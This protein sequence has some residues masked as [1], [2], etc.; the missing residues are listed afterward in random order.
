MGMKRSTSSMHEKRAGLSCMRKPWRNQWIPVLGLAIIIYYIYAFYYIKK[1][2]F[3][4]DNKG[5][6]SVILRFRFLLTII[7]NN[8]N[9]SKQKYMMWI[10]FVCHR[11]EKKKLSVLKKNR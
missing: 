1:I 2:R 11:Y 3:K 9:G 5:N 7:N 8:Q 6:Y 10:F 4:R